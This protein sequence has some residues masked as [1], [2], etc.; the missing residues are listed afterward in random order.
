MG[1]G[2]RAFS[3]ALEV[4][5]NGYSALENCLGDLVRVDRKLLRDVLVLVVATET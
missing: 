2:G 3:I 4:A 5:A 1:F